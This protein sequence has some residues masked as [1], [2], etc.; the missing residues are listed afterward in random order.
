VAGL[1]HQEPHDLMIGCF[2]LIG[3]APV[4]IA[5][6]LHRQGWHASTW[7]FGESFV[8]GRLAALGLKPNLGGEMYPPA[9][10]RDRPWRRHAARL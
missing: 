4:E 2:H 3:L 8:R 10:D 5:T 6:V 9:E 1:A 7:N